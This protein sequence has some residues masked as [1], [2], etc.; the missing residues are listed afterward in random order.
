MRN[1]FRVTVLSACIGA[2]FSSVP[3][4]A[5][6]AK[7]SDGDGAVAVIVVTAQKRKEKLQEVPMSVTAMNQESLEALN[8]VSVTSL[9]AAI[10]NIIVSDAFGANTVVGYLRGIGTVNAV[11]SQDPAVGIYVDDVYLSRSLGANSNF[12]DIERVEVLR[13]PQGTLYGSNSPAGAIRIVTAK[14]DL[15]A[16]YEFKAEASAGSYN[17][18]G[19]NLSANL[20]LVADKTAARFVIMSNRRDG[21]QTSLADGSKADN[22]DNLSFR[23]HLLT[24]LSDRWDLLLSAD[25]LRSRSIPR[26]GVSF[27]AGAPGT[28]DLFDTPGFN[29]RD[30]Y[31]E[32]PERSRYDNLDT[33]GYTANIHGQLGGADFRSITAYRDLTEEINGDVDGTILNRF[34]A[35]QKLK[36]SQVTQEFN[37][38]GE[39]GALNWMVGAFFVHEKNDF[40]WHVN[41]LQYL[42][43]SFLAPRGLAPGY[44]LFDQTKNSWAL[45]TQESWK[46]TDRLTLT[47]GLRWTQETKDFH[48]VGYNQTTY[49]DVG[50]PPGTPIPGF[51]L[52]PSKTWSAP[53]WRA[54]LDYKLTKDA[55]AFASATRGFRSGG[56][57]GGARSIAEASAAPF[58]PEFATTYEIGAKT[59][60]LNRT[61]RFNPTYFQTNY[62]DQ[63][64]AFLN[65]GGAFGTSTAD[66]KISGWEFEILMTPA[67]GLKLFAN[68]GTLK[69]E[70]TKTNAAPPFMFAPDPKYTYSFGFDYKRSAGNGLNWFLG[71][72]NF[73]TASYNISNAHDPFR[74]IPAY[75]N[76]GAR[77]GLGSDNGRWKLELIGN[78][79]RND[80]WPGWVFN[81]PALGTQER[82][83]NAP[84]TV[85]LKLTFNY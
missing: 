82:T 70:I 24:K 7:P 18:R 47:G 78:N 14:P 79:L 35:H 54:A 62:K 3:A 10:P 84:R 68:L 32:M 58:N 72:N 1:M 19:L 65:T 83:P 33:H 26:Q 6:T 2:M 8:I 13:G 17:A 67:K 59:E 53:Q 16:G 43:L 74:T 27:Y 48:V 40:L 4:V 45:F 36:N 44:Q 21:Y 69:G 57:N 5:Q 11:F 63:Q 80:Y 75:S 73:K 49:T 52:K 60:W 66:S 9:Q 41:F 76:L 30:F 85:D 38:S 50:I 29:K 56:Y 25:N 71:A 55:L 22:V 37:L 20:P 34:S 77:V 39:R 15:T 42:P 51:D 61:L 31:S 64:L 23:L 46:A 81:I 12:F 28:V